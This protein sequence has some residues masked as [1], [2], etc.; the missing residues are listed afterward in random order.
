M[1]ADDF[2]PDIFPITFQ[3]FRREVPLLIL[4][5]NV[6]QDCWREVLT[7][8]LHLARLTLK[9]RGKWSFCEQY[10]KT[11]NKRGGVLRLAEDDVECEYCSYAIQ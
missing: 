3:T 2:F 8:F 10:I 1:P 4:E 9:W 6:C 5:T 7:V 11:I